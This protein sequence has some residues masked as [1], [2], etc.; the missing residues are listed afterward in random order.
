MVSLTLRT[1]ADE[2]VLPFLAPRESPSDRDPMPT[3]VDILPSKP[4][5]LSAAGS[6]REE[7]AQKRGEDGFLFF[8]PRLFWAQPSS[9]VRRSREWSIDGRGAE[10]TRRVRRHSRA[11]SRLAPR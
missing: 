9:R 7:E 8:R 3:R 6:G 4:E 2:T 1:S 10:T 5:G 11:A